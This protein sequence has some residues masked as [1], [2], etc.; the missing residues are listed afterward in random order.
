MISGVS[1]SQGD[2][3]EVVHH[4]AAS[5]TSHETKNEA[6]QLSSAEVSSSSKDV[7]QQQHDHQQQ[8]QHQH[9]HINVK[10][11]SDS[12]VEMEKN[13][14]PPGTNWGIQ[15]WTSLIRYFCRHF[16]PRRNKFRRGL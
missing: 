8:Q 3:K 10:G 14:P 15:G 1:S 16:C 7:L 9:G 11:M 4:H 12:S 2:A 5:S 6:M 13:M